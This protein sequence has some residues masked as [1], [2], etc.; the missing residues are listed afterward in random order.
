MVKRNYKRAFGSNLARV[1]KA[2]KYADYAVQIGQSAVRLRK[3][4][5]S[6]S[7]TRAYSSTL[8]RKERQAYFSSGPGGKYVNWTYKRKLSDSDKKLY[9]AVPQ[10]RLNDYLTGRCVST[11]GRQN[12]NVVFQPTLAS[13]TTW[14]TAAVLAQGGGA[15]LGSKR[16]LIEAMHT[17][18]LLT[19]V[20]N[21]N[22]EI[23]IY[24]LMPI[25]SS[26]NAPD[27]AIRDG[28]DV[29][30]GT[31]TSYLNYDQRPTASAQFK[32]KWRIVGFKKC[33]INPGETVKMY[34]KR[35]LN[36]SWM[37]FDDLDSADNYNS[38]L[39]PQ[40]L[41]AVQGG[42]A[43]NDITNKAQISSSSCTVNWICHFEI[44][45]RVADPGSNNVIVPPASNLVT[46]Y[47]V[48]E[49]VM[50]DDVGNAEPAEVA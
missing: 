42:S 39:T 25:G 12:Y 30:G 16:S 48:A 50:N 8:S 1:A 6:H 32:K 29:D 22:A 2:A 43:T 17:T 5:K 35:Y 15:A 21:T 45:I 31:A 40:I 33:L 10:W 3:A 41:L 26:S 49:N 7:G 23:F 13:L 47:T 19:N 46:A 38:G 24:E 20:E 28:I 36:K 37:N 11:P 27:V 44:V 34:S 4:V 9:H 14:S 18:L